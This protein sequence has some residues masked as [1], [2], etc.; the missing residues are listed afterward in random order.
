MEY[1]FRKAEKIRRARSNALH[2]PKPGGAYLQ[3]F[4]ASFH[5]KISLQAR[6]RNA[7]H[8]NKPLCAPLACTS[9]KLKENSELFCGDSPPWSQSR[10]QACREPWICRAPDC[11]E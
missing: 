3:A 2:E 8:F 7:V 4:I 10:Q 6:H 9:W 11:R 1:H 5:C